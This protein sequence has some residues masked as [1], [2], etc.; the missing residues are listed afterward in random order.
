MKRN[1]YLIVIK[2]ILLCIIALTAC[3]KNDDN[4]TPAE[5]Q[6]RLVKNITFGE[7][8]DT[9]WD[10]IS[11]TCKYD[12]DNKINSLLSNYEGVDDED[13]ETL[14]L[15]IEYYKDKIILE[16][17]R[18]NMEDFDGAEILLNTLGYAKSSYAYEFFYYE[19]AYEFFYNEEGFLQQ[20]NYENKVGNKY[21]WEDGNM[22]RIIQQGDNPDT[23]FTQINY[24]TYK[25]NANIDLN[26]FA[27]ALLEGYGDGL[28]IY[29]IL[30]LLG[31]SSKNLIESASYYDKGEESGSTTFSYT[32]DK[33][34]YPVKCSI[35]EEGEEIATVTIE[36]VD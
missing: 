9:T 19:Y 31:K 11:T 16:D 21:H 13:A 1:I 28:V 29:R 15:S 10:C 8:S 34:G 5:P 25:N 27:M 22:T 32:F 30:N 6:T 14:E 35:K 36:Y 7:S 26:T 4:D 3:S 2:S 17:P 23:D 24:S 12:K 20:I 33:E 18:E